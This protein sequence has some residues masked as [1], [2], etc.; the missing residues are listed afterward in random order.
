MGWR[1]WGQPYASGELSNTSYYQP[2]RMNADT[3][4]K[5]VR[6]WFIVYNDPVFTS[7]TAKI[8]ATDDQIEDGTY[9]PTKLLYTSDSRTKAQIHNADYGARETWFEFSPTVPLEGNTWYALVINGVGYTPTSSSYLCWMHS[10]PD[11]VYD[12][13]YTATR[14]NVNKSPFQIYFEGAAY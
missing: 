11:A 13:N 5:T 3:I 14:Y 12:S 4:V 2:F 10:Y 6:T 7:L 9:P 8:Y 1:V